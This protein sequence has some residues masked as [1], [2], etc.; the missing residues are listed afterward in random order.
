M[1]NK[2]DAP[3]QPYPVSDA[4]VLE[5]VKARRALIDQREAADA[6]AKRWS[7]GLG[8]YLAKYGTRDPEGTLRL[9][10]PDG[11]TLRAVE[12]DAR[13]TVDPV[14]LLQ[15]GVRSDVIESCTR[16]NPVAGYLAVDKPT[17][18]TFALSDR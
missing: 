9:K 11:S 4:N 6:E 7:A 3:I 15:A 14:L 16:K 18:S 1:S 13:E 2:K 8:A 17:V 5:A 10:L 12:P